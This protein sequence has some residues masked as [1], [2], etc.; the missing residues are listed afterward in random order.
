[1]TRV[2]VA[3][4]LLAAVA[5]QP[6]MQTIDHEIP[7]FALRSGMPHRRDDSMAINALSS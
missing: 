1:V 7:T 5:L 2:T 4:G 3:L 6:A